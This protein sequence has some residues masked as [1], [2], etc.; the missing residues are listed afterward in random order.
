MRQGRTHKKWPGA[1]L[2][3]II[4]AGAIT[5]IS[6]LAVYTAFLQA[7][8]TSSRQRFV[9]VGLNHLA[10]QIDADSKVPYTALSEISPPILAIPDLP[11]AQLTRHITET[12]GVQGQIKRIRYILTWDGL[13]GR[14]TLESEYELTDKGLTNE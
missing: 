12:T 7:N 9:T 5:A 4:I 1:I 14:Q 6:L 8:R 13:T 2:I 11:K 10:T 3:E